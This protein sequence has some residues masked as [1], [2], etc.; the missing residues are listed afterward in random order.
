M[1]T[2]DLTQVLTI[3]AWF[4]LAA[5]LII[6]MLIA[7]YYQNVTNERTHYTLFAVPI[8]FF[9]GAAAHYAAIDQVVGN[10]L[11]DALLFAGGVILV[12]L[13]LALYRRMT[14]GR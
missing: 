1:G 9:A 4:P 5:F 8:L 12:L 7:R 3:F 11:G 6:T 10:P 13:S 14:T 2:L